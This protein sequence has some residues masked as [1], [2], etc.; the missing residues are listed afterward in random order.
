[1]EW[2]VCVHCGSD[3]DAAVAAC[4]NCGADPSTGADEWARQP[5]PRRPRRWRRRIAYLGAS[6]AAGLVGLLMLC[7]VDESQSR[8][9]GL[10]LFHTG[11]AIVGL[12]VLVGGFAFVRTPT[13]IESGETLSSIWAGYETDAGPVRSVPAT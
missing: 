3:V 11:C 6:V 9:S 10:D 1:V 7:A 2:V 8:P 4:P 12:V 13:S 5:G